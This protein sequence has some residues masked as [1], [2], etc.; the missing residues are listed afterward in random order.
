MTR[1]L[2]RLARVFRPSARR[3]AVRAVADSAYQ[4]GWDAR[5]RLGEAGHV[6]APGS[7]S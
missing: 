4:L 2:A 3:I 5:D 7:A 1:T 6:P